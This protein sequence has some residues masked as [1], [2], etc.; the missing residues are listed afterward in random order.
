MKKNLFC[1]LSLVI[2]SC[3]VL[4]SCDKKSE[5]SSSVDG[6]AK[7]FL[8]AYCRSDGRSSVKT[9]IA[10]ASKGTVV[11]SAGDEIKVFN[12][13]GAGSVMSIESGA[14][15]SYAVFSGEVEKGSGSSYVSVT[16]SSIGVS[17]SGSVISLNLP[18][19]QVYTTG[20]YD[21]GACPFVSSATLEGDAFTFMFNPAVGVVRLGLRGDGSV[22][23]VKL[24]DKAGSALS[25]AFT[26]DASAATPAAVATDGSAS[27][28][29]DCASPV[30]LNSSAD[31]DFYIIVPAGA[32]SKGFNAVVS[33]GSG[34]HCVFSTSA[35][36]T[37]QAGD[38]KYFTSLNVNFQSG[39]ALTEDGVLFQTLSAAVSHLT[40]EDLSGLTILADVGSEDL[41]VSRKIILDGGGHE[42]G[43]L[44]IKDTG[45]LLVTGDVVVTGDFGLEVS[46]EKGGQMEETTGSITVEGK[47]YVEKKLVS[48]GSSNPDEWYYLCVPFPVD[49]RNGVYVVNGGVAK[50]AIYNYNY[51]LTYYNG[52]TCLWGAAPA[53]IIQPGISFGIGT[54]GSS[55]FRFYKTTDGAL[56]TADKFFVLNEFPNPT[57]A[58][59][60]W[61]G[62]GN[63]QL[64]NVKFTCDSSNGVKYI[65]S[66]HSG[67]KVNPND[68]LLHV[69]SP[70]HIKY[71]PEQSPYAYLNRY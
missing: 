38:L 32:L 62:V 59:S 41:T 9:S 18:S 45:D 71:E 26:V 34:K 27:V 15:T 25:G 55:T 35:D 4:S 61:N 69:M 11:W 28:T 58:Y 30:A 23:S 10:D 42:I 68:V 24:T 56:V 3:T 33:D 31:T 19:Q 14:G 37:I 13:L 22:K 43:A 52:N 53:G 16:P 5:P 46:P 6:S 65:D 49:N 17:C 12:N 64:Y 57:W 50:K 7:A 2:A 47:S 70:L 66:S 36:N 21:S 8:K 60:G 67:D 20:S 29:L 54:D 1:A 40:E 39:V 44:L 51:A 48:S 63:S